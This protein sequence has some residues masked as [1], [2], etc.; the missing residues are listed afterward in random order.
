VLGKPVG[1][2]LSPLHSQLLSTVGLIP[3]IVALFFVKEPAPR[4]R[5]LFGILMAFVSGI[6]SSTGNIVYYELLASGA[7][8]ATITPLTALSPIVTVLLAVILLNERLNAVQMVGVALSLLAIFLFNMQEEGGLDSLAIL[9]ALAP[10]GLW[11]V[12][13]FLQKLATN[14]ISA[15]SSA[16]WFLVAFFPLAGWILW[17]EPVTSEVP[18]RTW[19]LATALGFT[20]ALG[21]FTILLAFASGAK[22]SVTTPLA[23]L[24]PLVSVPIAILWFDERIG[25]RSALGVAFALAAVAMLSYVPRVPTDDSTLNPEPA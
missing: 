12:A 14:H 5:R 23:G 11:G 22:A 7:N 10:I 2:V 18:L 4:G 21:N 9:L 13:G 6:A 25:L 1:E 20:L 17:R 8:A 16:I 24:Y 3:V 19:V 15:G